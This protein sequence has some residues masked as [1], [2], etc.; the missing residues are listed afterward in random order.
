VTP[1]RIA[2][3]RALCEL[4][5]FADH[6]VTEGDTVWECPSCGEWTGRESDEE[7]PDD[8]LC[9]SCTVKRYETVRTALPEALDEI[10]RL[11][12]A[13]RRFPLQVDRRDP[14]G[15]P[16]SIPW[17]VAELAYAGYA[18]RFGRSQ[19][20]ERLAERG[21]FGVGEMDALL[22][23]WRDQ[24]APAAEIE[25]LRARVAEL[26]A[27]SP[28][29]WRAHAAAITSELDDAEESVGDALAVLP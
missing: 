15:T 20:L 5:D 19:S 29:A 25:R 1:E 13:S 26:E 24:I 7:I 11:R 17:A 21:G 9:L 18:A 28:A 27:R 3:L 8:L 14:P 6:E 12:A 2:E 22:P 16:D 23:D 4:P 10:E